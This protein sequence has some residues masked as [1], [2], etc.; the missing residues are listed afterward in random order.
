M[1]DLRDFIKENKL[2]I[3]ISGP[4]R[5]KDKILTEINMITN[6]A[7]VRSKKYML[8]TGQDDKNKA[9]RGTVS[10]SWRPARFNF[11]KAYDSIQFRVST[12]FG[13]LIAFGHCGGTGTYTW[14]GACACV[15]PCRSGP[16]HFDSELSRTFELSR[17]IAACRARGLSGAACPAACRGAAAACRGLARTRVPSIYSLGL[18][19]SA[20]GV[21]VTSPVSKVKATGLQLEREQLF[22][23]GFR[24]DMAGALQ[25]R[26]H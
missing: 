2:K 25:R 13:L 17:P 5:T 3:T 24:S 1:S 11:H 16:L 14:G 8:S 23:N 20:L 26:G 10:R 9:V 7:K 19:S 4:G 6:D 21:L 12:P 15:G 18:V 22:G